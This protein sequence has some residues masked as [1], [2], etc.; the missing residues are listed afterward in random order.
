M[1]FVHQKAGEEDFLLQEHE[2]RLRVRYYFHSLFTHLM[3]L[4]E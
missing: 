2:E 1:Y 3:R 4:K